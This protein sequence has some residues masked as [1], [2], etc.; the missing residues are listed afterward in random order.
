MTRPHYVLI[1]AEHG[2]RVYFEKLQDKKT[3]NGLC[4]VCNINFHAV[5]KQIE[6]KG[7]YNDDDIIVKPFRYF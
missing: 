5:N 2:M 6:R 4:E 3:G 1:F 7:F